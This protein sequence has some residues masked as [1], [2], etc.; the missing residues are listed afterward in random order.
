MN[1]VLN[2]WALGDGNVVLD[3]FAGSGTVP[4]VCDSVGVLGLGIEAHS[5]VANVSR[6][7]LM[8]SSSHERFSAF[9]QKVIDDAAEI[10]AEIK[11]DG[12]VY[13][14]LIQR[15]FSPEWLARLHALRM[16]WQQNADGSEASELTWMAITAILRP[17]SSAGTAQWQYICPTRPEAG[18]YPDV[19]LRRQVETM[20][21]DMR[22]MQ[23]RNGRDGADHRRRCA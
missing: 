9:V 10:A 22:W 21:H 1:Q 20:L 2:D 23:L 6:A 5:T 7:K 11:D 13:P 14:S 4:L 3:P 16:A 12:F 8:W 18:C 19:A 17:V 15:S